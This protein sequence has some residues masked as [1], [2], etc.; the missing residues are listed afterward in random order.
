MSVKDIRKEFEGLDLVGK[1]EETK[2]GNYLIQDLVCSPV[3]HQVSLMPVWLT[4]PPLKRASWKAYPGTV[5]IQT[6]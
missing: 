5:L 3:V 4:L 1:L 6:T 2:E